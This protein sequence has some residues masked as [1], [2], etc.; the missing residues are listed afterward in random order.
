MPH[1]ARGT[2]AARLE[3]EWAARVRDN[4]EQVDRIRRSPERPDFYAPVSAHFVDEPRRAGD[5]ILEALLELARPGETWLD[6][7][8]GAGRYALPLA[9]RVREVLA[10]DP[11]PAMLDGLRAAVAEH[12]IHNVRVF[13]GRWPDAA[14]PG[15]DADVALIAQV[16]YDVE[17]IGPFLD[18]MEAAARRLCVAIMMDRSPAAA[19][20]GFWPTVHGMRRVPL[21]ALPELVALLQA[22]G[23]E[24]TV[25]ELPRLER[26]FEVA[27]ETLAYLRRQLWAE[28]GSDADASLLAEVERRTAAGWDG[29]SLDDGP[30]RIGLVTWRP[31]GE[32]AAV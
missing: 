3:A 13:E 31:S 23:T 19:A 9:L 11:S 20:D 17:R 27:E 24:P 22:R 8:A 29:L 12:G 7:G 21:P 16:G 4:R 32:A 5:A 18:A 26:R 2:D 1:R 10:V 14:P 28:E 6:I 30:S 25:R 15:L